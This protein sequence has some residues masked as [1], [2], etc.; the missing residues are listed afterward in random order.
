MRENILKALIAKYEA[1]VAEHKVNIEVL[2]D[3]QVGVAEHPGIIETIDAELHKL[4]E[5]EDKLLNVRQH[6]VSP[7]APKVV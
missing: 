4:A 7:P 5:A 1:A 3:K 6:F 2:L